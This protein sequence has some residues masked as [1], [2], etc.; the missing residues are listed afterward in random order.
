MNN[1]TNDCEKSIPT[2]L[3]GFGAGEDAYATELGQLAGQLKAAKASSDRTLSCLIKQDEAALLAHQATELQSLK[4]KLECLEGGSSHHFDD[5]EATIN[6]LW[7]TNL[8]LQNSYHSL[9]KMHTT[10]HIKHQSLTQINQ[11]MQS[12][13]DRLRANCNE[14]EAT[15]SVLE[16]FCNGLALETE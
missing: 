10:T 13:C 5:M 3:Q 12:D 11:G 9:L 14:L 16:N 15:C 2:T 1:T 4:E 8:H 6:E 7:S